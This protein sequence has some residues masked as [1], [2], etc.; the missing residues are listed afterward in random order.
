[1]S[2]KRKGET[3]KL[4]KHGFLDKIKAASMTKGSGTKDEADTLRLGTDAGNR[5]EKTNS[6]W[7]ALKDDYMMD[8]K[9][10]SVGG[11]SDIIKS[12]YVYIFMCFAMKPVFTI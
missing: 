9:K 3:L 2:S 5:K 8:S 7:G 1:V 11:K 4:T 12:I 6:S 10:V